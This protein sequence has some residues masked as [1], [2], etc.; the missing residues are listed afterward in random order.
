[1][2]ALYNKRNI[3]VQSNPEEYL[4]F[5]KATQKEIQ[6]ALYDRHK[7]TGKGL[8]EIYEEIRN[9]YNKI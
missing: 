9:K 2:R 6:E 1:M 8:D 5:F 4:E 3:R 7:E